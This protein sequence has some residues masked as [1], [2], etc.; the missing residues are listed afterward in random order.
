M[1]DVLG[2]LVYFSIAVFIYAIAYLFWVID[3]H[4]FGWADIDPMVLFWYHIGGAFFSLLV[5]LLWLRCFG[6]RGSRLCL[7]PV[8]CWWLCFSLSV[9]FY[10]GLNTNTFWTSPII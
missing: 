2:F 8:G 4:T 3:K 6:W 1:R 7:R 9:I 10:L 5:Q